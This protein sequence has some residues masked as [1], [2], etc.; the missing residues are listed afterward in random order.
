VIAIQVKLSSVLSDAANRLRTA[1]VADAM[2]D[3][4]ILA[5]NALG[6][7][8]EDMLREPHRE[9]DPAAQKVFEDMIARRCGREPVARILGQREFRSLAFR[10]DTDTLEPRPDSET[11]VEAAVE[12][13]ER[14]PVSGAGSLRVLDIGTGTGCLLLAVLTELPGSTGVGT[15]IAGGAVETAIHN[16]DDLNLSDRAVFVRTDWADGVAG[17]FDLVVSNPPYIETAEIESLAPEVSDHDPMAALD[18]GVDGLDAYRAIAARLGQFLSPAGIA[19]FEIGSTQHDAVVAIFAAQGFLP[20]ET[21]D[22]FGGHP[23]ALVFAADP[24]PEWLTN[25]GKKG[26]ETP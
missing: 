20:V 19:V 16:S 17:I 25:A 14:L 4:R 13:G 24:L 21:R 2:A 3:A 8:R 6:L 5:A 26:L 23:R 7:S 12:Y 9:L 11:I 15:D 18:G 22:D 1:G 10:L